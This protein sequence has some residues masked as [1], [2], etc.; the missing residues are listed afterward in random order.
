MDLQLT[1]RGDYALRAAL[2]LAK[3]SPSGAY[4]KLR[5]IA[6]ETA[7]PER[8]THEIVSLLV[9]AGLVEAMAGK[10]GGYRL[11]REPASIS[12]LEVIEA[13]EGSL[14]QDRCALSGGPCRQQTMCGVH[15]MLEEAARALIMSLRRRNLSQIADSDATSP[16]HVSQASR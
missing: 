14:R 11:A 7:I 8:Y 12:L 13:G 4:R 15:Q 6:A 10:L 1:R 9:R 2:C 3:A 16:R 5:E